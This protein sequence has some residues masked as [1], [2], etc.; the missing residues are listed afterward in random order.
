[1]FVCDNQRKKNKHCSKAMISCTSR[2]L[3]DT[4]HI[5]FFSF[6]HPH[7]VR[8]TVIHSTRLTLSIIL[9]SHPVMCCCALEPFGSKYALLLLLLLLFCCFFFMAQNNDKLN[10]NL[11]IFQS[12]FVNFRKIGFF[13]VVV[14]NR[15][16]TANV[17][18]C[19]K[20]KGERDRE[21]SWR[22]E[23]NSC[24]IFV[25]SHF[26]SPSAWNARDTMMSY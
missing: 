7:R 20:I 17:C 5:F 9:L 23:R 21:H 10:T 8:I 16:H 6:S 13:P 11:L 1:M 2:C 26:H 18:L 24:F 25:E 14:H 12:L 4:F 19:D 3:L 15:L 22:D